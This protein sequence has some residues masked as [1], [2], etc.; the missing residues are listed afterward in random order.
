[1]QSTDNVLNLRNSIDQKIGAYLG[2]FQDG[3][4]ALCVDPPMAPEFG[5]GV[6]C[7][8]RRHQQRIGLTSNYEWQINLIFVPANQEEVDEAN[9]IKFDNALK[10]FRYWFSRSR[11]IHSVY[12]GFYQQISFYLNYEREEFE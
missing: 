5:Q 10:T 3:N 12:R 1:M 4:K 7:V 6:H 8:I 9:Q 2:T 11:E